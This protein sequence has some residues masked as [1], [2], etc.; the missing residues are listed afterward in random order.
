MKM[1]DKSLTIIATIF[2]ALVKATATKNQEGTVKIIK[3]SIFIGKYIFFYIPV[4]RQLHY[5]KS[6]VYYNLLKHLSQIYNLL[7]YFHQH[8]MFTCFSIS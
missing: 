2:V 8:G 1:N 3:I 4:G 6:R 5:A 7:F